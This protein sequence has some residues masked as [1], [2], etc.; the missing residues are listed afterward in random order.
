LVWFFGG[1]FHA[2]AAAD[3]SEQGAFF[4]AEQDV[5]MVNFNYR[6]GIFGFSGAPGETQNVGLLDQRMVIE[7]ARDNIHAFGGDPDRI[8]IFRNSAGDASV[9]FYDYAW[10]SDPI[11]A[12]SIIMSGCVSSSAIAY[13][14]LP[15]KVGTKPPCC[16][17]AAT[18][19]QHPT[20]TLILACAEAMPKHFIRPL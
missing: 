2:G 1:G 17:V 8:T 7:W 4:V 6:L 5:V 14:T 12:G 10:P 13:P 19:P 3:T 11:V 16:W 20:S 18:T 9:D 15:L